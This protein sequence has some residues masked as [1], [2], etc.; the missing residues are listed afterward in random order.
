MRSS[1]EVRELFEYTRKVRDPI[2]NYIELTEFESLV[3]D[4]PIFQRLDRISQMHSVHKV[5]PSAAYS[6]KVHSLGAMHLVGKAIT[7]L[8]YH[9]DTTINRTFSSPIFADSHSK[10]GETPEELDKLDYLRGI[11]EEYDEINSDFLQ[12]GFDKE[13]CH[14]LGTEMRGRDIPLAA[15]HVFQVTRLVGLL[16]DLGHGPFSHK[17]ETIS[18]VDFNHENILPEVIDLIRD[19]ARENL[20]G[21]SNGV[22]ETFNNIFNLAELVVTESEENLESLS[23]LHQLVNFPFDCDMLDYV[24]RDAHFSGTPEYGETDA[25]R[26]IK[27]FV[28]E[29]G[30]LKISI[31]EIQALRNAFE[32]VFDMYRAVYTHKTVRMYDII[33]EE[34]FSQVSSWIDRETET[35]EGLIE[36]DD[37]RFV[38][39]IKEQSEAGNPK[40][41]TAWNKYK[42]FRDRKK[43]YEELYYSPLVVD[44]KKA[45]KKTNKGQPLE[46]TKEAVKNIFDETIQ[47]AEEKDITISCD[48]LFYIRRAG[49]SLEELYKWIT[50]PNLYAPTNT[51]GPFITFYKFDPDLE[52]RLTRLEIPVRIYVERGAESK[53]KDELEKFV[54]ERLEELQKNRIEFV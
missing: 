17:L 22:K 21:Y 6:R 16:H 23:F 50:E 32:S 51:E 39:E 1:D 10:V 52:E 18:G 9:Q 43:P 42:K 13:R 49:L 44:I 5:Y 30:N 24:V 36:Y 12:G 29:E 20:S 35:G 7:R 38:S 31:S 37:E 8:L 53:I 34:S 11:F 3:I 45:Q 47:Q 2:Y 48:S 26:I 4:T 40:F 15:A 27:G 41:V 46:A 28:V 54:S 19:Q 25:E 33:L 14:E